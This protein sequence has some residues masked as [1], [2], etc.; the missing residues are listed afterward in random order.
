MAASLDQAPARQSS[1]VARQR[2]QKTGACERIKTAKLLILSALPMWGPPFEAA[3]RI[4]RLRWAF[5]P[6]LPIYLGLSTLYVSGT[7][8]NALKDLVS[9][10]PLATYNDIKMI[11]NG[12]L[13]HLIPI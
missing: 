7:T 9:T 12:D 6:W 3:F 8:R 10:I 11:V 5:Q 4:S 2:L 13:L 1:P